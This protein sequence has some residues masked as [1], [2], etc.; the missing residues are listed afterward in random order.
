MVTAVSQM[1]GQRALGPLELEGSAF[2]FH[3][4]P[5]ASAN[6]ALVQVVPCDDRHAFTPRPTTEKD[7][8]MVKKDLNSYAT[9]C[10]N[11]RCRSKV[12]RG[13]GMPTAGRIWLRISQWRYA[14]PRSKMA[15]DFTMAVC[16]PPVENGCGFGKWLRIC[17]AFGGWVTLISEFATP[18]RAVCRPLSV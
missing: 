12:Q 14:D 5:I 18:M 11:Q 7:Q 1:M 8:L 2:I 17:F 3:R 16:R 15:A 6:R 4:A 10:N 13:G 9:E